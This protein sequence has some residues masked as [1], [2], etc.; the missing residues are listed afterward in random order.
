MYDVI[1]SLGYNCEVSFRLENYF[2]K[3]N[4]MPFS[5]SFEL[6]RDL[7]VEALEHI[8]DLFAGE[9]KLW[10]DQMICDVKYQI[11]FHPRYDI[12]RKYG[13]PTEETYAEC[14]EE[15]RGRVGHLKEKYKKLLV[16]GQSTL[17][18]MKVED[19]GEEDN[20]AY[21]KKI[22]DVLQRNYISGRYTLA[23]VFEEQAATGAVKALENIYGENCLRICTLKKFAPKK[24][25]DTMGDTAGWKRILSELTGEESDGYD[26][27][28]FQ[29]RKHWLK[30][31]L[32][33]KT[34]GMIRKLRG[35]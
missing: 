19:K 1:T 12:L 14:V 30:E 9:V 32:K 20:I 23:A 5:W 15:L 26:K 7:F 16:S 2:G 35:R 3:I 21:V 31:V 4:A 24:H 34:K 6:N 11:K 25:T 22:M 10:D 33:N 13:E 8:D 18:I 17:F 27:R 28:L 29:R